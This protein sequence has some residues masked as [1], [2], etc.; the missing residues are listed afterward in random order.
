[1][2]DEYAKVAYVVGGI[3]FVVAWVYAIAT[4][5]LF[6]GIGLG[7]IPAAFIGAIAGLLWPVVV[8]GLFGVMLFV[9][10]VVTKH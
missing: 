2:D 10:F 6:L 5:G 9:L 4:Y 8:L 1:M 3:V 7:W